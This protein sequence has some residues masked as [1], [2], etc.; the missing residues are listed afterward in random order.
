[1]TDQLRKD[2]AGSDTSNDMSERVFAVFTNVLKEFRKIRW[3]SASALAQYSI[4]HDVCLRCRPV[5]C[6]GKIQGP[7]G[8]SLLYDIHP[9]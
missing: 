1:M 9:P 2:L 3:T 7:R 6:G 4:S 8:R 5:T